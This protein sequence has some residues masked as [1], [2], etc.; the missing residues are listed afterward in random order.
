MRQ[1]VKYIVERTYRPILV[2]Y[3]SKTRFYTCNDI[4]LRVPPQVFHPGFFFST[5]LLLA[6][7]EGLPLYGKNF[8]ELGAGSGL[9][10]IHAAK[11]GARVTASDINPV[12]VRFL[13]ENAPRNGVEMQILQSDLFTGIPRQAFDIM[14]INPPYY[15][16]KP[17]SDAD[18]AWHCGEQGEYFQNLFG[19]LGNY[20]HCHSE[21][22]MVLCDG[23]DM[24][25]I[26]AI[27]KEN[28]FRLHCVFKKRNLLEE[29][30]IFRIE[31]IQ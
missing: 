19:D 8:L 23:C 7:M 15:K 27:A 24:D 2:S 1:V 20:A 21:I 6:Y 14:A 16:K 29:N 30:F 25:M 17:L 13:K 4:R 22:I 3:L 5:K 26:H 11:K 10:A 31:F 28:S 9:I 18:Y 12:A